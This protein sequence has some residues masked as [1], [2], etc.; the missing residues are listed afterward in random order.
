MKLLTI[1][2]GKTHQEVLQIET[3]MAG[4]LFSGILPTANINLEVVH[5][6]RQGSTTIIPKMPLRQ[7]AKMGVV[8]GYEI[9]PSTGNGGDD[10]TM[11]FVPLVEGGALDLDGGYLT[12]RIEKGSLDLGRVYG[13]EAIGRTSDAY[14]YELIYVNASSPKEINVVE[15]AAVIVPKAIESLEIAYMDGQRVSYVG[16]EC[17]YISQVIAEKLDHIGTDQYGVNG[18]L[19]LA[20]ENAASIKITLAEQQNILIVK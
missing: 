19:S 14:R 20:I 2:G 3:P 12:L 11:M 7:A 6:T 8:D 4:L 17:L 10:E 13:M 9:V 1:E 16:E 18:F 5:T 15:A